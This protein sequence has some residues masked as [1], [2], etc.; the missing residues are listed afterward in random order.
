MRRVQVQLNASQLA[1]LK[2]LKIQ[3]GALKRYTKELQSYLNELKDQ[4]A[5]LDSLRNADDGGDGDEESKASDANANQRRIKQSNIKRQR[6]AI[7][8]TELVIKDIRPRLKK[9][10]DTV[11]GLMEEA[12]DW[13]ST[14]TD[15][16]HQK[17]FADTEQYLINAEEFVN[18][19][20]TQM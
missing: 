14:V 20:K 5:E 3:S 6:G 17:L 15:E 1:T 9:V 8:E 19:G 7:Q 10:W 13:K 16:E 4:K 11:S 18:D 2:S 12:E